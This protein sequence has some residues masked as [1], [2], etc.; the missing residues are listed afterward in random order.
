MG[1]PQYG[2]GH[3]HNPVFARVYLNLMYL[4]AGTDRYQELFHAFERDGIDVA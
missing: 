2:Q 3:G 4:A 1:K